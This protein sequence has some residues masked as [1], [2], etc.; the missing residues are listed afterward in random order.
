MLPQKSRLSH[1]I[2]RK[3][4]QRA[5][6]LNPTNLSRV[7]K[8]QGILLGNFVPQAGRDR[9]GPEATPGIRDGIELYGLFFLSQCLVE[10]LKE[11]FLNGRHRRTE[12]KVSFILL[13]ADLAEIFDVRISLGSWD[14][15]C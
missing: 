2:R 7:L 6:Q 9:I 13:L 15:M 4:L 1:A 5:T 11:L 3:K 14:Q 8:S 12:L 10:F